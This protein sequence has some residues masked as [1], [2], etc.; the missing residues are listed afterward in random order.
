MSQTDTNQSPL[1]DGGSAAP[2]GSDSDLVRAL[3]M[4]AVAPVLDACGNSYVNACT[5]QWLDHAASFGAYPKDGPFVGRVVDV[6]EKFIEWVESN[7]GLPDWPDSQ[8][9]MARMGIS[10]NANNAAD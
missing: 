7:G 8:H 6:R 9:W 3:L 10:Q 1:T 4:Y 2:S 5:E